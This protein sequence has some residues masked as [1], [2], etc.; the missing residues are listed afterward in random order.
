MIH[1]T[2]NTDM[3][4]APTGLAAAII[5]SATHCRSALIPTGKV[6]QKTSSNVQFTNPNK[7]IALCIV[8]TAI[9]IKIMDED[10]ML[11]Q[12]MWGWQ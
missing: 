10:S 2:N 4:S 6:F 5:N 8:M 9:V 11:G 12:N 1:N 3:T 7:I